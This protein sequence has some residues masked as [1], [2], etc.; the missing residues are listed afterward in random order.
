MTHTV[1]V[2]PHKLNIAAETGAC[3]LEVL[4][5][6]G[7]TVDAPC[8]GEGRC[9]KCKVL[10]DGKEVLA[11]RTKVRGD[12]TVTLPTENTAPSLSTAAQGEAFSLAFDIGTTTVVAFLL[13]EGGKELAS[14]SA[15]N[16]QVAFGA[17]VI[18]RIRHAV[19]GQAEALTDGIRRCADKL[20]RALCQRCG[21]FPAQIRT[22]SVVGN[23]AMQQ[24]FLGLPVEGLSHPPFAPALTTAQRLSAVE[25]LPNFPNAR[26]L[27]LP[28][29]AG[30]VGADTLACV[31]ATNMDKSET[32]SL[33]VDI[34]TNGE[35][36][37]GD[38][39]RMVAC[40]TAAG[41]ALEGAG[42]TWGMRA[43][44]G[45]IDH[46]RCENGEIVFSVIGGGEPA[47]ICGTGLIDAV[48]A[49]LELELL[50]ER[51]KLSA[52]LVLS[53]ISLTQEDIRAVQQA[54][55]A[56]AAGILLMAEQLGV[57]LSDIQTVYLAGAFGSYL[58]PDSAFRIGLLP[59]GLTRKVVQC[60]NAAGSGA[61][62]L[63]RDVNA[64]SHAEQLAHAIKPLDLAA[65]PSFS[66]AFARSMYFEEPQA[67]WCGIARSLGFE[68]A[69]P[70]DPATLQPREEVRA[71]CKAD[72]CG[73]Y[74][75]NHTC[76][77]ACGALDLCAERMA[78][79]Q[80]G[81][82]VQTVGQLQ[83]TI[84]TKG[85]RRA[86]QTHLQRFAELCEAVRLCHPN[87]LC[88]GTGGCRVCKVCSYPQ[89][90]RFP[91]QAVSSMEAYGLFVTEVC[92]DNGLPY[93]HG[94]KTVTYTA[95]ILF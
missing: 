88:L 57:A 35:M 33:L 44:E 4:R 63:A 83:K 89:P 20:A 71:M 80:K 9:G 73:A 10:A 34:G 64:L 14:E 85:Y 84:D 37:L 70:L 68:E 51:G 3:L 17:D 42:I 91:Q 27:T 39:H 47:G 86:E 24:L 21:I 76:P 61:K 53:G 90:C 26:L 87:A 67:Y 52:P 94:E 48:A 43:M 62:L 18:S 46:A 58:N 55:G 31:L 78:G 59:S 95:C 28:A 12:M 40:S 13:D 30:F 5:G 6:A 60:G 75:K 15:L 2:L 19:N 65:L 29:V 38:R 74:G 49:A 1:T 36:V 54:K 23:P 50:N 25:Y 92:R 82:L 72:K 7:L 77:P 22:I 66:R 69:A 81:I 32:L 16:P 56:I 8:G 11:C 45:A 79:F 41:P 93:H